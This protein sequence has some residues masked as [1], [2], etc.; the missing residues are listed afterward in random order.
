[1]L[2]VLH[3]GLQGS[4]C[5]QVTEGSL[6]GDTV[7]GVNVAPMGLNVGICDGLDDGDPEGYSI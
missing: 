4:G 5:T 7:G 6:V 2:A 1:M 3:K